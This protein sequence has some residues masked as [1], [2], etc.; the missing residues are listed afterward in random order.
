MP[1]IV[2]SIGDQGQIQIETGTSSDKNEGRTII[3]EIEWR[4]GA[5]TRMG[6]KFFVMYDRGDAAGLLPIKHSLQS[7]LPRFISPDKPIPSTLDPADIYTQG[8]YLI[9]RETHG[10]D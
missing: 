9:S 2:V 3:Q 6:T 4:F 1:K 5:A 10:Y 7:G 8:M